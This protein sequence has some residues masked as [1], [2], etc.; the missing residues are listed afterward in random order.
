MN[1]FLFSLFNFTIYSFLGW[2][3]ENVYCLFVTGGFQQDGFLRG[4]IKP[5]YGISVLLLVLYNKY[6]KV[7]T[8]TLLLLCFI[9][10]TLIEYLSGYMLKKFF[11]KTYWDYSALTYNFKGLISLRFSLYW[12]LLSFTTLYLLQP[13]IDTLY[14]RF[15]NIYI[16]LIPFIVVL[17][18]LDLVYTVKFLRL[19]S[20][21]R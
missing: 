4:P 19:D 13:V 12:M 2:I 20:L 9:I 15:F 17:L 3:I 11:N 10:P 5:M 1:L 14:T 16:T 21:V 7:N 18:T 8:L 6:F